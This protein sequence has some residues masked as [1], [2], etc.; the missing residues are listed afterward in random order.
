MAM[1]VLSRPAH[2]SFLFSTYAKDLL[3]HEEFDNS[4]SHILKTCVAVWPNWWIL[5]MIFFFSFLHRP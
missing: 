2:P 1:A 5:F 3:L 4:S